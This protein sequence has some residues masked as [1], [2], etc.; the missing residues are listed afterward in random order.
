MLTTLNKDY[1][2]FAEKGIIGSACRFY[3]ITYALLGAWT[4]NLISFLILTGNNIKV[5]TRWRAY[6]V[7]HA[8]ACPIY[9]W[10]NQQPEFRFQVQDPR[11]AKDL[12]LQ[13]LTSS[14][15][16]HSA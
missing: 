13:K 2:K 5:Q 9:E 6:V 12:K 10:P 11:K 3:K 16:K 14:P 4:G 15:L 1:V 8:G 7:D